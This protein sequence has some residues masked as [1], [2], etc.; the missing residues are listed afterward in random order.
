PPPLAVRAVAE[1]ERPARHHRL[2]GARVDEHRLERRP[3]ALLPQ[4]GGGEELVRDVPVAL[5]LAQSHQERQGGEARDGVRAAV[6]GVGRP[7]KNSWRRTWPIAMASA[8]SVPGCG[9]S[10]SSPNLAASL[11]SGLTTTT[12]W[13]R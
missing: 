2:A 6:R 9:A 11:K 13:P 8:P 10:H 7:V 4:V 12:F 5:V 1:A 3:L